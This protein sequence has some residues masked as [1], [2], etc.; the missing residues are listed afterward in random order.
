MR[1]ALFSVEPVTLAPHLAG[2][3]PSFTYTLK[4]PKSCT[5]MCNLWGGF[6]KF[7]SQLDKTKRPIGHLTCGG[8]PVYFYV[9]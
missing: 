7:F 2:G 8:E 5:R 4:R 1:S 3:S 6:F 9:F